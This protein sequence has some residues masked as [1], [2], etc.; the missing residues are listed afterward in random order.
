[1]RFV[2]LSKYA[3]FCWCMQESAA[4][5]VRLPFPPGVVLLRGGLV[6]TLRELWIVILKEQA[7]EGSP[8][9]SS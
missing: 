5:P 8:V 7:T 2:N 1:M 4:V 6:V 9:L 3:G